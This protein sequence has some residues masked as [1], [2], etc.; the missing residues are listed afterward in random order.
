MIQSFDIGKNK[1][2]KRPEDFV[3]D[4][5]VY[6]R[7]FERKVQELDVVKG[8]LKRDIIDYHELVELQPDDILN[9]QE[10]I[11]KKL[12]EIEDSIKT[13]VDIGDEVFKQRQDAFANDMSPEEIKTFAAEEGIFFPPLKQ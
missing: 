5:S 7:D 1:F 12:Y 11:G 3:F 6:I 8:E 2:I 10:L 13:L 9:L 4:P